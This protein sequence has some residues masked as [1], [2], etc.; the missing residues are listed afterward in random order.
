[1]KMDDQFKS[2]ALMSFALSN[3]TILRLYQTGK[4]TA[5]EAAEIYDQA[6][7]TLEHQQGKAGAN[8]DVVRLTRSLIESALQE[9]RQAPDFSRE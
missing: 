1:M 2:M 4:I 8:S 5:R 3:T 7:L 9:I 6:L